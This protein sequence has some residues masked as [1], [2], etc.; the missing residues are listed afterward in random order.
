MENPNSWLGIDLDVLINNIN[1]IKKYIGN[2]R[3][4]A[5]VKANAYGH[6]IIPIAKCAVKSGADFLGV[7]S[8]E[9]G[10]FL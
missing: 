6:G 1:A 2:T 9:E 4:L 5:V 7:S 3:L 10:I 8:L